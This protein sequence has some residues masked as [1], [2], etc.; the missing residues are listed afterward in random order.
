MS[1]ESGETP[2]D[3]CPECG[4]PMGYQSKADVI[5]RQ[6][7]EEF[8]HEKRGSRDLLWTYTLNHRLDE[9]V[10]RA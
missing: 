10:A 8:C 4:G 2:F 7:G 5:C 1:S 6:C 9:V 3:G